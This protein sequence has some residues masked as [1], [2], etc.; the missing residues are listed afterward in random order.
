MEGEQ[1]APEALQWCRGEPTLGAASETAFDVIL[2][3][4]KD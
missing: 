2:A 4:G 3:D 1:H